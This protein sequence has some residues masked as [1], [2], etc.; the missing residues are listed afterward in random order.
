MFID[1]LCAAAWAFA[2][3]VYM[4]QD[5]LDLMLGAFAL[6]TFWTYLGRLAE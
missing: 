5:K 4:F 2:G 1:Y 6:S 3:V